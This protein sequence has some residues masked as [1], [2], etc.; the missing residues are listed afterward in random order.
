MCRLLVQL[1]A[2]WSRKAASSA[3]LPR[4]PESAAS[5][6]TAL[7]KLG[8]SEAASF[9]SAEVASIARPPEEQATPANFSYCGSFHELGHTHMCPHTS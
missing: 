6:G 3:P 9:R 5:V 1:Q 8:V 7:V 2:V 4:V